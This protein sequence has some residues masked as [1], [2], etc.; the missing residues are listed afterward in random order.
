MLRQPKDDQMIA[1]RAAKIAVPIRSDERVG[2]SC[3][4]IVHSRLCVHH[5]FT[6]HL[7]MKIT[8]SVPKPCHESWEAMKSETNGRFC[9][10]CAHTVADLTRATD[11][12]LIAMLRK[13]AFP[14]CARF[15]PAQLDRVMSDQT[16]RS[17]RVMPI[18]AFTSLLA[19]AVGQEV[20]A[21]S[22]ITVK[23]GKAAICRPT[24]QEP[25][26][27]GKLAARP[28][29]PLPD[30]LGESLITGD[31]VITHVIDTTR[32]QRIDHQPKGR[33]I[34]EQHTMGGPI[35]KTAV[36]EVSEPVHG[37]VQVPAGAEPSDFGDLR[38]DQRTIAGQVIDAN[39]KEPLP[40]VNVAIIGTSIGAI[41]DMEGHFALLIPDSI[42]GSA[43]DL[44]F[45]SVGY[46]ARTVKTNVDGAM[47]D[48]SSSPNGS[49]YRTEREISGRVVDAR[50]GSAITDATITL[51]GTSAA[52]A[53]NELGLF[54]FDRPVNGPTTQLRLRV[55]APGHVAQEITLAEG[56][57]YATTVAL[58]PSNNADPATALDRGAEIEL[59]PMEMH[60]LG[61]MIITREVEKPS[62]W[63]KISRPVRRLLK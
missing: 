28:I 10:Q 49:A 1:D 30:L 56:P 25:I 18:A 34:C 3:V 47:K 51:I 15:D 29:G 12:E 44:V 43:V 9:S 55:E 50:T 4:L 52:G 17:S 35:I 22:P 33:V 57:P 41:A 63:N 42:S 16:Q 48:P 26:I 14:K 46:E 13:E 6:N 32:V 37:D 38:S 39:T 53:T 31:T 5:S 19:V 27:M 54:G 24:K 40:F 59:Y 2:S 36:V 60:V 7:Q 8:L 20:V 62:M 58:D 21:Q 61:E 23:M 45:R 11:A